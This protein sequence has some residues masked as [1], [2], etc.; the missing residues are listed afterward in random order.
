MVRR[1][2]ISPKLGSLFLLNCYQATQLSQQ[3]ALLPSLRLRLG[4]VPSSPICTVPFTLRTTTL[5]TM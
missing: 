3:G 5:S 1:T 4:G 2:G